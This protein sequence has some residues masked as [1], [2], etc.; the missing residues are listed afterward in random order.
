MT[1]QRWVK[2]IWEF[3]AVYFDGNN[4]EEVIKFALDKDCYEA[5]LEDQDRWGPAYISLNTYSG[6]LDLHPG[7]HLVIREDGK[8]V[9]IVDGFDFED[10][11]SKSPFPA[12]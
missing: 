11:F 6:Y 1:S 5:N 7:N 8:K 2:K 9:K 4:A 12:P 10:D 3:D